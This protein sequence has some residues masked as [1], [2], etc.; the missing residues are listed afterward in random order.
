[1]LRTTLQRLC[2]SPIWFAQE[3]R[4]YLERSIRIDPNCYE[5]YVNLGVYWQVDMFRELREHF[6]YK[7]TYLV[8]GGGGCG[9]RKTDVPGCIPPTPNS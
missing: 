9:A 2:I 1:M 5:A 4:T 6:F 3:A 8:I 7:K